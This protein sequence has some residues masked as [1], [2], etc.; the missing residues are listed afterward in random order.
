MKQKQYFF[1]P[2]LLVNPDK[3]LEQPV[4]NIIG[5]Q[6]VGIENALEHSNRNQNSSNEIDDSLEDLIVFPSFVNAHDH[7]LGSYFP[8]VGDRKPY[9]HWKEWDE[10]LK[11][12]DLY[13]ERGKNENID[14]YYIGAYRNLLSGVL[15][16]SDHIPHVVNEPFIDRMPIRILREYSLAHEVSNFDLNWGEGVEVEYK[17]AVENDEPFITHIEEGFDE[18]SVR[19]IEYLL[20]M[21]ALDE[22]TVLIH[23]IALSDADISAIAEK[24][25]HLVWC[26]TSNFYMF[27]RTMRIKEVLEAGI[28]VS[29]GTDSPMS[30]SENILEEIRFA[31]KIYYEMY[32]EELPNSLILKMVT[33]NPAKA[34]RMWD[35]GTIEPKKK[36]HFI[37]MRSKEDLDPYS[38]LVQAKLE[39][40]A[41]IFYQGQPLY[42]DRNF[43]EL[44]EKFEV[45]YSS[46]SIGRSQKIIAGDNPLNLLERVRK[47]VG[48]KKEFPFLPLV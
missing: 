29:L 18:E 30:G 45:Q 33:C 43:S 3:V 48:Y 19:G 40:I 21:S 1:R 36:A 13:A 35:M 10:D 22:H 12:S 23:G 16:V 27:E 31:K 6:I 20:N 47:T 26:P 32:Q 5:D 7:L 39:D 15:A 41:L 17:K 38:I 34:L 8:R 24:K 2:K 46:F 9:L 44:F 11:S 25:A 4:I 42:G 14:L 37:A 28:N